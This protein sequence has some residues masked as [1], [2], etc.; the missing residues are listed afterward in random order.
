MQAYGVEAS[1]DWSLEASSE[2][3]VAESGAI[4]GLSEEILCWTEVI[5]DFIYI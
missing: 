1:K 4:S 2:S 5:D 3:C